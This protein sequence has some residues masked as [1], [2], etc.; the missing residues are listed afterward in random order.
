MADKKEFQ[1]FEK[2]DYDSKK[3]I[4]IAGL[5]ITAIVSA[6]VLFVMLQ[7]Q[8]KSN[9]K[10]KQKKAMLSSFDKQSKLSFTKDVYVQELEKNEFENIHKNL[11]K[12]S[13]DIKQNETTLTQ[14]SKNIDS[15]IEKVRKDLSKKPVRR[16][17][18]RHKTPP[19]KHRKV[20]HTYWLIVLILQEKQKKQKTK[21][22]NN[23]NQE[24]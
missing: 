20:I 19:P 21:E 23:G 12:V 16:R 9:A 24:I 7:M 17:R 8:S 2:K 3:R 6:I 13:E 14:Q 15:K 11:S 22:K 18:V 4:Q 1:I 5:I 10:Q